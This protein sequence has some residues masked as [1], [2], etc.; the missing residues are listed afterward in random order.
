MR[1]NFLHVKDSTACSI[2]QCCQVLENLFGKFNEQGKLAAA[3]ESKFH[4]RIVK[5]VYVV[6]FF[7]KDHEGAQMR[8][9]H[10]Y[11]YKSYLGMW[12]SVGFLSGIFSPDRD[13]F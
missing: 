10:F 8:E 2:F 13:D 1:P 7:H 5:V 12:H 9:F 3:R 11:T 6:I 4:S